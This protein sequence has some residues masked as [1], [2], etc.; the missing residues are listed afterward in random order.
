MALYK[1]YYL[2]TYLLTY[3]QQHHNDRTYDVQFSVTRQSFQ[4]NHRK[5]TNDHE[6]V[7]VRGQKSWSTTGFVVGGDVVGFD[8]FTMIAQVGATEADG[9]AH[10][11]TGNIR[12]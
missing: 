5:N 11:G 2:L 12:G 6:V 1:L 10:S 8:C 7:W 4:C 3:V 9:T